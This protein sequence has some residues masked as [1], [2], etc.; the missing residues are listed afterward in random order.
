MSDPRLLASVIEQVR[1]V[2]KVSPTVLITEDSQFVDDLGI[3]SLDLVSLFLTIQ[4]EFSVELDDAEL[5]TIKTVG[6]LCSA[7]SSSHGVAAA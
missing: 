3:D 4:V 1:L 7:I 6:T 5:T 2:C